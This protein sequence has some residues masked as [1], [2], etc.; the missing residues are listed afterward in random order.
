MRAFVIPF[1]LGAAAVGTVVLAGALA[2]AAVADANGWE[3]F[4]VSVGPLTLLAFERADGET[5]ATFGAALALVAAGGGFLN[6][7]AAAFLRRRGS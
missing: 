4:R 6:A 7:L 1:L 3:A 2:V 5:A